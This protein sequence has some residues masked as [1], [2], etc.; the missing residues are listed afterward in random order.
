MPRA[1][2]FKEEHPFGACTSCGCEAVLTSVEGS[3][4][5]VPLHEPGR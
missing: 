4:L 2:T 3:A 5:W 1:K